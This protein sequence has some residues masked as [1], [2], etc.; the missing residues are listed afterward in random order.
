MELDNNSKRLK[1][2]VLSK[3]CS[4][5]EE[6]G[7]NG[8]WRFTNLVTYQQKLL[9]FINKKMKK[10]LKSKHQKVKDKREK[11]KKMERLQRKTMFKSLLKTI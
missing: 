8:S 1:N 4:M 9:I 3:G 11:T 10:L 6:N 5:R 7:S 2:Q